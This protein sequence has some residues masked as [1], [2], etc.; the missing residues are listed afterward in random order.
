MG[1]A[2]VV[3]QH[4]PSYR[5]QLLGSFRLDDSAG[6]PIGLKS[7]E[8]RLIALSALEG[9]RP[10]GYLAGLLW[11]DTTEARAAA[12]LRAAVCRIEHAAPGLLGLGA[13]QL[14]FAAGTELDVADL[15]ARAER[16]C[17]S[18]SAPAPGSPDTEWCL[19]SLPVL[20]RGELLSGWYD[21]WACFERERLQSL[22]LCALEGLADLLADRGHHA[23]ALSAAL[24]A[25]RIDPL[26][27]SAH[28]A[29]IRI[30]LDEGNFDAALRTYRSFGRRLVAELG[31]RPSSQLESLLRPLLQRRVAVAQARPRPGV[32]S[33]SGLPL[34][35]VAVG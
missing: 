16:L 5:V 3:Q 10:R 23:A 29:L 30:H 18:A 35:A 13:G 34:Q 26:R 21:E 19:Q 27:E 12:S 14:G 2:V 11:P 8:Q 33:R 28:R 20:L 15:A 7:R 4:V 31:V 17:R 9:T 22:R 1:V 32:G 6:T 24:G 25:A